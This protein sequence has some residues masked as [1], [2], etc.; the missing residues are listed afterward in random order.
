MSGLPGGAGTPADDRKTRGPKMSIKPEAASAALLDGPPSALRAESS[1]PDAMTSLWVVA[2]L[3]MAPTIAQGFGRFAYALVL[4]AMR[5]DLGWSWADAGA[6]GTANA[7]GYLIGALVAAPLAS[8]H[9]AKRVFVVSLLASA[10]AIAAAAAFSGYWSQGA[11]R[12]VAGL[13]SGVAFVVGG[14]LATTAGAGGDAARAPT[15]IGVY[16]AGVGFG[17]AVS[18]IAV[19]PI[20]SL[21]GW[22]GGW[23]ALGALSLAAALVALPAVRRAPAPTVRAS[24]G[25]SKPFRLRPVM[26][27]LIAYGLLGAG[28]IAYATFVIAFLQQ[29]LDFSAREISAFWAVLGASIMAF[30]F[31]WGPVLGRLRG[32]FGLVA[33]SLVMTAGVVLV[34]V[35]ATRPAA[36]VSAVLFGA[37]GLAS[38]TA[39]TTLARRLYPPEAWTAAIG[40]LTVAFGAGQIVGPIL[41]GAVSD[42]P[43]G[44]AAGLTLSVWILLAAIAVA[45]LQRE[46]RA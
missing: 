36:Y 13:T 26:F 27:E 29:E 15:A 7:I 32:G 8:R 17:I 9:G 20:L 16:V 46:T 42:G 19:P 14:A 35:D 33:T 30:T 21:A 11:L 6:M 3:A 1:Q 34:L 10:F 23:L 18:A 39:V 25:S 38:V 4:P 41:S 43:Q 24:G 31:V 45:A 22:R 12:L 5:D 2:G 37:S 44:L 40:A 28:Y